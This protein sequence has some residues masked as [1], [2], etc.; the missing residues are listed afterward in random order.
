MPR[1]SIRLRTVRV[2]A[3][4]RLAG[5]LGVVACGL[6]GCRQ[7]PP[8]ADAQA[9]STAPGASATA[10]AGAPAGVG[11]TRKEGDVVP[12]PAITFPAGIV[13]GDPPNAAE[14]LETVIARIRQQTGVL[15]TRAATTLFSRHA[16]AQLEPARREGGPLPIAPVT[17]YRMF[18]GE[19]KRVVYNGGR[20]TV[21]YAEATRERTVHFFLED[22]AW[23]LDPTWHAPWTPADPGPADPLNRPI[24]PREATAGIRGTGP[25]RADIVTTAGTIHCVLDEIRAPATVANFVG[26]ARGIRAHRDTA[27]GKFIDAW[28]AAPFYEG[29]AFHRVV[30]GTLIQTGCPFDDGRGHAGYTIPDE[31]SLRLRHDRPGVLAMASRGPNTGSSQFYITAKAAPWLDDRNPVFGRCEDDALVA[32]ISRAGAQRPRVTAIRIRRG[33][34]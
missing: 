6:A 11:T 15:D 18:N 16:L 28:V 26:L 19:A 8:P 32:R 7:S 9:A 31:L 10:Q 23:R 34:R 5:L 24:S 29:R 27:E 13:L 12:L 14:P 25:L 33:D 30:P 1:P 17:L 20:A 3:W 2:A 21:V 22:G 4:P